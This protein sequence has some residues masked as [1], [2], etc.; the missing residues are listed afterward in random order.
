MG[1]AAPAW[2]TVADYGG[3]CKITL[4]DG[5][6]VAASGTM[7]TQFVVRGVDAKLKRVVLKLLVQEQSWFG[8]LMDREVH[9]WTLW[10]VGDQLGGAPES[11]IGVEREHCLSLA[12]ERCALQPPRSPTP[13][14]DSSCTTP[15][16]CRW[17][18]S[19]SIMGPSARYVSEL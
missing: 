7:R 13:Q 6:R 5:D 18:V 11:E 12:E 4:P 10:E 9:E 8:S 2:M 15:H 1:D 17:Q 3:H 19:H 16:P 14:P